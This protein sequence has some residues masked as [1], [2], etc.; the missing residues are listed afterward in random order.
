VAFYRRYLQRCNLHRSDTL[1]EVNGAAHAQ[2][3]MPTVR[4][5]LSSW[6]R[7]SAMSPRAPHSL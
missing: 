7:K 6:T 5:S 3:Q 4:C 2:V 1:G